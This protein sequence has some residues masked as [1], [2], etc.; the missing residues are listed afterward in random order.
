MANFVVTYNVN[1]ENVDNIELVKK[2]NQLDNVSNV[3]TVQ[4][5]RK[6]PHPYFPLKVFNYQQGGA[7]HITATKNTYQAVYVPDVDCEFKGVHLCLTS[8]NIEDTYDVMIGSRYVIKGSHVKEMSEYRTLEVYEDVS[9]G[10]PITI[11]FHNNSGLEKFLLYEIITL[12]DEQ[13][14]NNTEIMEWSFTWEDQTIE[15]G[16]QD[17]CTL[18]INQPNYVNMESRIDNFVLEITDMTT[19]LKVAIITYDGTVYSDYEETD[20]RYTSLG[21]LARVNV[22]GIV[23]VVRYDKAIQIVFKNL[24]DTGTVNPHPIQIGVSGIVQNYIEGMEE[25]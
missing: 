10:T 18:I 1:T 15:V 22:I 20:P 25:E 9:A 17:L 11:V 13:V 16:E 3:Q 7:V 21:L 5:V 8:Y 19:F 2:V 14:I 6:L 23:A 24:N 4:D 12:V